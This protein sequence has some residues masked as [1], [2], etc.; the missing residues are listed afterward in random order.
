MSS[1]FWDRGDG[2]ATLSGICIIHT[3][4]E[5]SQDYGAQGKSWVNV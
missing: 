4:V 5:E 3:M 1:F 2:L